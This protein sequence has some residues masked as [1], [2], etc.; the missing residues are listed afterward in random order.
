MERGAWSMELRAWSLEHRVNSERATSL[1]IQGAQDLHLRPE[2]VDPR[3]G[4]VDP[5]P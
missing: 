3:P 5:E 4:T 1:S 2:S